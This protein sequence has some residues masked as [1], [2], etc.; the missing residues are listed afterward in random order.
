M[1]EQGKYAVFEGGD[2]VGKSTVGRLVGEKLYSRLDIDYITLEEPGG[3]KDRDGNQLVPLAEELRPIIKNGKL[4]RSPQ[5]NVRLF[6]IARRESWRQA[7]EPYL[8]MGIWVIGMRNYYSTVAYQGK[9]EGQD[10]DA[11]LK[12]VLRETSR[13]YMNPDFAYILDLPEEVRLYRKAMRDDLAK[14]DNFEMKP[15]DFQVRVSEGYRWIAEEFGIPLI[16]AQPSAEEVS[17][18]IFNDIVRRLE[19]EKAGIPPTPHSFSLL[20]KVSADARAD[21]LAMMRWWPEN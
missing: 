19:E 20:D 11:I 14:L 15:N 18:T 13:E 6:N 16:D 3:P 7:L 2:G 21:S 10:I 12:E 4:D 17:E 1:S 8:A 5:S 9:G